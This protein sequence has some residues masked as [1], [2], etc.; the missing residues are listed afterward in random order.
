MSLKEKVETLLINLNKRIGKEEKLYATDKLIIDFFFTLVP[1]VILF[2]F[3]VK[4]SLW[5]YRRYGLE[6]TMIVL[7]WI[8]I[9]NIGLSF[10]ELQK[11]NKVMIQNQLEFFKNY[12]GKKSKVAQKS[13]T[14]PTVNYHPTS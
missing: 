8:L 10:Q 3:S 1:K 11:I 14:T 7:V 12:E 13:S 4:I 6:R 2:M 9:Y 5:G